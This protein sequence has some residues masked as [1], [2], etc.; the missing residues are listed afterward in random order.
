MSRQKPLIRRALEE[1]LPPWGV[2]VLESHH[3]PDFF[4]DWRTHPFVKLIYV[5]E[6]AGELLLGEASHAFGARDL[7]VVPPRTRNR[8]IDQPGNPASLYV[9]CLEAERL[10]FDRGLVPSLRSG[11]TPR[12]AMVSR[13]AE[14]F[15]RRLLFHQRNESSATALA[16]VAGAL[17][18]VQ[19]VVTS[20][21][22]PGAETEI[23]QYVTH[24]DSHF[25]EASDIDSVAAGLGISRRKF[26]EQFRQE[27]GQTWLRYV[28]ERAIEHACQLLSQ[29][30][31]PVASI[32]FECGFADLSTFYRHFKSITGVAPGEWRRE[33]GG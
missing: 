16:M 8:L 13:S 3:A 1:R 17:G 10:A 2:L 5:L 14:A 19:S 6:G 25:Y 22:A 11:R 18:L 24:L 7:L 30:K 9:L 4:M 15:F 27:T 29:T 31:A 20:P 26:T 21:T 12:S 23:A 33:Q 28:R 32:A